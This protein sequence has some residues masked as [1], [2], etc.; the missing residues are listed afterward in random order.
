M[1]VRSIARSLADF[2]FPRRCVLCNALL[3]RE[4]IDAGGETCGSCTGS[5]KAL[6]EHHCTRCAY[7]FETEG[8]GSHLCQECLTSDPP[9]D[10]A[11]SVWCYEEPVQSAILNF[12]FHGRTYLRSFF[13]KAMT[14]RLR[15][16]WEGGRWDLIIP[17]PLHGSKLRKRGYNQALLIALDVARASRVPVSRSVLRKIRRTSAQSVLSRDERRT[18]VVSAFEVAEA[19]AIHGKRVLL[20]DDVMTTGSTLRECAKTLKESGAERVDCL[21]LARAA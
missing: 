13:S 6:P 5:L 4:L 11:G 17:V 18:N 14:R 20:I 19:R 9:F 3:D 21:T 8:I 2:C 16:R 12:K 1:T 15:E 10:R 7:P